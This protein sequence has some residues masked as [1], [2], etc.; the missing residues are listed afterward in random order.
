MNELVS[1]IITTYNRLGWLK[2]AIN[3]VQDQSYPHI[4]IIVVDSSEA[5]NTKDYILKNKNIIYAHSDINHPNVL[6]NIGIQHSNG[7]WIAFLD[8]DD[9]WNKEKIIKQVECFKKNKI[10]LCYTGKN[11]INENQEN[12]KY[13]YKTGMWK[14]AKQSIMWDNFIGAT[15]SIMIKKNIISKIGDF[16]ESFPALQDYEFSIRVCQKYNVKGINEPLVNYS[17]QHHKK[18][19][20]VNNENFNKACVLLKNKYPKN[21][22]L[23][24]G[25]W[26]LKIKRKV[27]KIYE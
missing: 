14:V 10:E 1:V 19:I 5:G 26:K 23:K 25:L 18:Q 2:K 24:F 27:K 6:R 8:D 3:S 11:I 9:T 16:D 22:L 20:S 13:S 4:E 7:T 12:I 21:Y 15:S 17:Y